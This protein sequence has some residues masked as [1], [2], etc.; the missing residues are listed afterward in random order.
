MGFFIE[1]LLGGLM[2]GVLYSLYA[3]GIKLLLLSSGDIN[4]AKGAIMHLAANNN[5]NH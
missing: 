2:A 5:S 4:L 1:V 3:L